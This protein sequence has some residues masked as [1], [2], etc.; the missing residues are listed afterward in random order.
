MSFVFDKSTPATGTVAIFNVKACALAAG[1]SVPKSGDATSY[2]SSSDGL[3]TSSSGAGGLGNAGAW[4]IIRDP[5]AAREFCFQRGTDTTWR[6][7]YSAS[8]HFTGG[9]PAAG[10]TP[11]AT[12][13]VVL[14]GGGTD[15]SPSY[16]ALLGTN[17]TYRWNVGFDNAAPYGF[18]AAGFLT[19]GS[20]LSGAIILEPVVGDAADTDPCVIFTFNGAWNSASYYGTSGTR[21]WLSNTHTTSSNFVTIAAG[22]IYDNGNAGLL[23]PVTVVTN[24]FSGNDEVMTIPYA[25][26]AGATAPQ[27]VKGVGR[28]IKWVGLSRSNGD[29]LTVSTTRD[30]IVYSGLA[31]PWDGTVPTV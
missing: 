25:R 28:N 1:W 13:E 27:G 5:A 9:S 22:T 31:L 24:P 11:S 15:A 21:G 7:K 18:W 4:F 10:V 26:R 20:A 12:D 2:F 3:T 29:A 14:H 19:G 17:N 16:S 30:Y 8:A 6:I 23:F